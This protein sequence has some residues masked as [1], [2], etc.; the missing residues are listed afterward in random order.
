M[1]KI[2]IIGSGPAAL[3]AAFFLAKEKKYIIQVWEKRSGIARKLLIAGSSGLNVGNNSSLDEYLKW[4]EGEGAQ[5]FFKQHLSAFFTPEWLLFLKNNLEREVFLGTSGRYFIKEMKG[6]QLV[7]SWAH[8][9]ESM[10]VEFIRN[11]EAENIEYTALGEYRVFDQDSMYSTAHGVILAIGGA[12]WL[13][14]EEAIYKSQLLDNL[15]IEL[16]AFSSANCGYEVNWDL[17]LKKILLV[18]RL[19]LKQVVLSTSKGSLLGD[20][21]LTS[22]GLEGA[23]VYKVGT[24]GQA[25]IDLFP[26]KSEKELALSIASHIPRMSFKRFIQKKLL[27]SIAA[28]EFFYFSSQKLELLTPLLWAQYLKKIPF[29]FIK[30]RPLE[31]A[32]SSGG[33]VK[34]TELTEYLMVKRYPGLFCAGEMVD[35]SAPTGGYL[36]HLAALMGKVAAEG[37]EQYFSNTSGL[38]F[39]SI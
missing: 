39:V 25:F 2:I 22:Y 32:I 15:G 36:I 28:K 9:L 24:T 5:D 31:E 19:P 26:R 4:I 13:K 8:A 14:A 37:L 30:P 23:P 35:F 21:L 12:S 38:Q 29:T 3:T 7:K 16:S 20:L 1:K 11:K 27:K 34:F 33:G 18:D 6:G 10:G 17:A